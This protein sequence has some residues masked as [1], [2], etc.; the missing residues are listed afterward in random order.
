MSCE[1]EVVQGGRWNKNG[2]FTGGNGDNRNELRNSGSSVAS[3]EAVMSDA[4]KEDERR[5]SML[6]AAL[7]GLDVPADAEGSASWRD[8]RP[9][10]SYWTKVQYTAFQLFDKKN[11]V[12][13]E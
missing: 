2:F 4:K 6:Q 9:L 10:L 13:C 5:S 7:H 3:C 12:Q 11:L 8:N 1:V